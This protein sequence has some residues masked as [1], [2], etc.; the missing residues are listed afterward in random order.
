VNGLETQYHDLEKKHIQCPVSEVVKRL[1]KLEKF[2]EL[3]EDLLLDIRW[4]KQNPEE[5]KKLDIGRI[6]LLIGVIAALG[7][8]IATFAK[9]FL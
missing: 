5:S 9:L 3:S 1:D 4:R 8:G 2:Q 7:T 6:I